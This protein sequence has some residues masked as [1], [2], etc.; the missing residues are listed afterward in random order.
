MPDKITLGDIIDAVRSDLDDDEIPASLITRK[1]NDFQNALLSTHRIRF[2][3]DS[4]TI[5]VSEGDYEADRPDDMLTLLEMTVF[6]SATQ[7]RSIK[8]NYIDYNQFMRDFGNFKIATARKIYEWTDFGN[9]FRFAAPTDA[10]YT[11]SIDYLRHPEQMANTGD[12]A[13]APITYLE[14]YVKG[15][16]ARVMERDEDYDEG[17]QERGLLGELI[18]TFVRN[19]GRGQIKIGPNIMNSRR[20][21]RSE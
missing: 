18:T 2:M 11:I 13:E 16:L 14:M 19:E 17:A 6:D 3:E 12:E 9:G 4:D 5:I 15:T 8:D 7:Y 1:A 21:R 10:Q 20:R